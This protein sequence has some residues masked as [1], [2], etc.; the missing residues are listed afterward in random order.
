MQK[1]IETYSKNI[2]T[3][4]SFAAKYPELEQ[5]Y[6]SLY[7]SDY[8]TEPTSCQVDISADDKTREHL[9]Y[10][11]GKLFGCDGWTTEDPLSSYKPSL[12]WTKNINGVKI[13]LKH[14]ELLE[15]PPVGI[16]VPIQK[17]PLLLEEVIEVISEAQTEEISF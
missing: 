7:I 15:K 3:L 11:L 1:Q 14:A 13:T 2:Q 9:K 6:V 16:P 10:S 17:F 12:H 5:L 4:I 8:S